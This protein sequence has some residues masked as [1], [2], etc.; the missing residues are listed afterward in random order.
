M[1]H[2]FLSHATD[3]YLTPPPLVTALPLIEVGRRR[4]LRIRRR[5]KICF[6]VLWALHP[7]P[8]YK[9]KLVLPGSPVLPSNRDLAHHQ[10]WTISQNVEMFMFLYSCFFGLRWPKNKLTKNHNIAKLW[11]FI[12]LCPSSTIWVGM[13]RQ[14][15]WIVCSVGNWK[16]ATGAAKSQLISPRWGISHLVISR[17]DRLA[18]G[19]KRRGGRGIILVTYCRTEVQSV[20]WV[21]FETIWTKI[22]ICI[23]TLKI[24]ESE[25]DDESVQSFGFVL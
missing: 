2:Y 13:V 3:M 11:D 25:G 1:R 22:S 6:F 16:L 12:Q 4:P 20:V 5:K 24:W 7:S 8:I 18:D 19:A 14:K 21:Y 23:W 9:E 10:R 15:S 17:T